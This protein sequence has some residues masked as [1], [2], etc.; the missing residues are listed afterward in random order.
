MDTLLEMSLSASLMILFIALL[1]LLLQNRLHRTVFLVL[2]LVVALRLT[3][4]VTFS[5]P[6]SVYNLLPEEGTQSTP[7]VSLVPVRP[8]AELPTV[9]PAGETEPASRGLSSR[10]SFSLVWACGAVVCLGIFL[11]THLKNR[12]SY[13]F[14]LPEE[15]PPEELLGRIR[16]RRLDS[17]SAP[18]V[19]GLFRPVILLPAHF[20]KKDSPEYELVLRHEIVHVRCG[21]LWVKLI[22]L[23]ITCVHWFNPFVWLMLSLLSMDLEMRCDAQVIRRTGTKKAYAEA[24]VHAESRR[25]SHLIDTCFAFSATVLRVKAIV[26]TKTHPLRSLGVCLLTVLVL[27]GC[28]AAEGISAEAAA[29]EPLQ[30]PQ[31]SAAVSAPS[32]TA[33]PS[34]SEEESLPSQASPPEPESTEPVSTEPTEDTPPV[35]GTPLESTEEA[36]GMTVVNSQPLLGYVTMRVGET[37]TF[38]LDS[39]KISSFSSYGYNPSIFRYEGTVGINS[40]GSLTLTAYSTGTTTLYVYEIFHNTVCPLVTVTVLPNEEEQEEIG[41]SDLD[42]EQPSIELPPLEPGMP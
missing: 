3:V 37:R 13:R 9:I 24:L 17:L 21:D 5:S 8:E 4:P 22:F 28:F 11:F 34:V 42:G 31:Q 15:D 32:E 33:L 10:E 16:L 14:S 19:Y 41:F 35:Q 2:W 36:Y 23:L 27:V 1:R 20:P 40:S 30:V 29:P 38:Y 12:L 18:L 39:Q 6:V 7:Q 25:Q 26:R